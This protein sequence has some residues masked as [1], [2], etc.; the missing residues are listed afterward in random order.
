MK[1]TDSYKT[2]NINIYDHFREVT[3]MVEFGN[4]SKH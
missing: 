1:G 3:K 4:G 2:K